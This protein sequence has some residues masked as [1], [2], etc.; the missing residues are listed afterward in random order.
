MPPMQTPVHIFWFRRDLRFDDNYG[1]FRALSAGLPV[2]PVFIFDKEILDYLEDRDDRRL[3]FIHDTLTQLQGQLATRGSSLDIRYGKPLEV[4]AQLLSEYPVR[5]VFANHD[6]EP[7]AAARDGAVNA[8][9]LQQGASLITF[10]DQVIF[11][12]DE[13]VKND[14]LPYGV[15]TPYSKK[16]KLQLQ[17]AH[18]QSFDSLGLMDNFYRQPERPVP[19]LEAMGF[20]RHPDAFPGNVLNE[21]VVKLYHQQRDF[22]ALPGTTQL[23]VHLR[24]GTVSI[25]RLVAQALQLNETFLGELIWREFFM[26]LLWHYPRLV[27]ECHKREYEAIRWRNDEKEFEAWCEGRT[28]YPIVD[29]GMRELNATGFMHNRVR[30]VVASFLIKHLLIDWRLGEGYFARKLLDFDLSAN[31]CNWQWVAGCGCDAAPYFRIFNPASQAK[32]F[33]GQDQ[34]IKRW[35]PE[36]KTRDYVLPI[37]DHEFARKRCLA[38]YK[39]AL[40]M[41]MTP[42][43][44]NK[45][46]A[47]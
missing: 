5:A 6:Y 31:N 17:P 2:V 3:T 46:F 13:V 24:F 12:K 18:Y 41:K 20:T 45:L 47:D 27:H 19:A 9:L 21:A 37:V 7:Y 11:E 38:A 26:Q 35:V 1:L 43:S 40:Q 39:E 22:P 34:Y 23:G 32:K 28:G 30:M 29:A 10:K 25:R 16:W 44:A 4:F 33:D 36:Y 8:L 14:G 15:Y 42:Q